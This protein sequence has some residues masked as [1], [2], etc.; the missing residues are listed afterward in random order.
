MAEKNAPEGPEPST[1]GPNGV[2]FRPQE[3]VNNLFLRWRTRKIYHKQLEESNKY[4][5]HLL[6]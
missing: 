3:G 4:S 2:L 1:R 6:T 5:V